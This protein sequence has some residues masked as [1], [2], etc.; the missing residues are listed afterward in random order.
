MKKVDLHNAP[1]NFIPKKKKLRCTVCRTKT[2]ST[3]FVCKSKRHVICENCQH[4]DDGEYVPEKECGPKR[5]SSNMSYPEI[6][7]LDLASGDHSDS[8]E[9]SLAL[10]ITITREQAKKKG[11]WTTSTPKEFLPTYSNKTIIQYQN[12]NYRESESSL[13]Q[14]VTYTNSENKYDRI[15]RPVVCPVSQCGKIVTIDSIPQHFNFD[16]SKVPKAVL[17]KTE[18]QEI[19]LN[20]SML[21]LDTQCVAI[22]LLNRQSRSQTT[23]KPHSLSSLTMDKDAELLYLLAAKVST[24]PVTLS[25]TKSIT[26][27]SRKNSCTQTESQQWRNQQINKLCNNIRRPEDQNWLNN[28]N[29]ID[30]GDE[31][32]LLWL[33]KLDDKESIYSITI[34]RADKKQAYSYIGDAIHIREEQDGI[35]IYNKADCL[36][37]RRAVIN[38]LISIENEIKVM[39]SIV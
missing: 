32:I 9:S 25:N 19:L 33:C 17:S 2:D 11:K 4:L 35:S 31:E 34:S 20:Y 28:S 23:L 14:D 18:P 24:F 3:Y 29:N 1:D 10:K 5:T 27:V 22:F 26:T 7:R 38:K 37:L 36:S 16:H 30:A 39:V 6:Q 15:P 8:I 12:K 13:P 21:S